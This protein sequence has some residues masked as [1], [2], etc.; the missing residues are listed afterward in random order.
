MGLL[1]DVWLGSKRKKRCM[2]CGCLMHP[3]SDTNICECCVADMNE[4]K[5]DDGTEFI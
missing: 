5:D 1:Y 3:D 4:G 2:M